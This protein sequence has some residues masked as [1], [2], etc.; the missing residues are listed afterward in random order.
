VDASSDGKTAYVSN[1]GGGRFHEIDVI[2]LVAHKALPAIDTTPLIGHMDW[3]LSVASLCLPSKDRIL[4][5]R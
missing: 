4:F 3:R 5:G 2:D 1:T